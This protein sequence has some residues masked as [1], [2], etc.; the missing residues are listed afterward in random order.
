MTR[1]ARLTTAE[2]IGNTELANHDDLQDLPAL[3][4]RLYSGTRD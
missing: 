4:E 1:N 3:L 2:E